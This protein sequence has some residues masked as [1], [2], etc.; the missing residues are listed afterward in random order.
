MKSKGIN[1]L[2]VTA[3]IF[4]SCDDYLT[5]QDPNKVSSESFWADLD[6]AEMGLNS[7]Y[8]ALRDI[9][10][11]GVMDE[12]VRSDEAVHAYQRGKNS[13]NDLYKQNFNNGTVKIAERWESLYRGIFY[14]NQVIEKT[15]LIE[16]DSQEDIED[17]IQ[18]IA[19]A[20][21]FRGLFHYWLSL[22]FNNGDIIVR[23]SVPKNEAEFYKAVSSREEV[24]KAVRADLEY[25]KSNLKKNWDIYNLGRPTQATAAAYLGQSYLYEGDYEPAISYF[26]FV[27]NEDFELAD[28]LDENFYEAGEFNKESIFEINYSA[29]FLA[30]YPGFDK[31]GTA[32]SISRGMGG[33]VGSWY[34]CVPAIWLVYQYIGEP[35]DPLDER[36]YKMLDGVKT[37]RT[38]PLRASQ[39]LAVCIDEDESLYYGKAP[40][41]NL[42]TNSWHIVFNNFNFAFFKKYTNADKWISEDTQSTRSGVNVRLMRLADIYLMHAECLIKGG[43]NNAGVNDALKYIN[44][45]R[46][47]S[48][49]MLYGSQ[50]TGEF[51]SATY[52]EV[53]YTAEMLMDKIMWTDRPL[54][55][56]VEGFALRAIDL[57]RWGKTEQRFKE[58]AAKKY[59]GVN[60]AIGTKGKIITP[61]NWWWL[62]EDP[63]GTAVDFQQAALNYVTEKHTYYPI[64]Q[65]EVDNNPY[66]E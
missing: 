46:Q 50:S 61:T 36:N 38:L 18:I 34:T 58:L 44:R 66:T 12:A 28:H 16:A 33:P 59:K 63:N 1:I 65:D 15:E 39:T 32:Q 43:S 27:E 10:T 29:A 41:T 26:E 57:R 6:E 54:E 47:R 7:V 19:Q 22:L 31:M 30:E 23:L 42:G 21:F 13:N 56:A 64:P 11:V 49:L 8:N 51:S 60:N 24:M 9:N 52:D 25:A 37:L 55:L 35:K 3:I 53:S 48:A 45:I 2:I 14:A 5:L 62:V 40:L 17:K 20:R 4:I